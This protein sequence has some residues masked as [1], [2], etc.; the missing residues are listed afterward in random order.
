METWLE[1]VAEPG[2]AQ[3][4]LAS[5]HLRAVEVHRHGRR[6]VP[7]YVMT[8]S[9]VPNGI[10]PMRQ[11]SNASRYAAPERAQQVEDSNKAPENG[12]G[13]AEGANKTAWTLF[14]SA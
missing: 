1:C 8:Q 3:E 4:D 14:A 7:R 5:D 6:F 12:T 10:A 2:F 11:T 13:G 9:Q